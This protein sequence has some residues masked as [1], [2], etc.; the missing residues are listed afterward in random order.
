MPHQIEMWSFCCPSV[1][2]AE[3]HLNAVAAFEPTNTFSQKNTDSA[4][5]MIRHWNWQET[6]GYLLGTNGGT[7][8]QLRHLQFS[9]WVKG[10]R[11]NWANHHETTCQKNTCLIKNVKNAF[12]CIFSVWS[13]TCCSKQWCLA[14]KINCQHAHVRK[15][16]LH[17]VL[18]LFLFKSVEGSSSPTATR[19]GWSQQFVWNVSLESF[20]WH[21]L[22]QSCFVK[23]MVA[24]CNFVPWTSC[25]YWIVFRFEILMGIWPRLNAF[26]WLVVLCLCNLGGE[27][28]DIATIPD[29]MFTA[30]AL[31]SPPTTWWF[32][33][34]RIND[35]PLRTR[36][37]MSGPSGDRATVRFDANNEK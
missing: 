15:R 22:C 26:F 19:H 20:G 1:F 27:T 5:H 7:S 10:E 13:W 8:M 35:T 21:H 9:L 4:L 34:I 2:C 14:K 23:K 33:S 18:V 29:I 32:K 37:F 36:T 3:C 31:I 11:S 17:V 28:M 25:R 16:K 12:N 30:F 6:W 24:I